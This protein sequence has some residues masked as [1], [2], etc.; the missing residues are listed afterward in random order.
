MNK[1]KFEFKSN[2]I[3]LENLKDF[4]VSNEEFSLHINN[5]FQILKT[6]PFPNLKN[7]QF[8][9]SSEEYISHTD[10]NKSFTDK[11]YQT[12]KK[13]AI[14]KKMK[15][16]KKY[17]NSE[18]I[19]LL[20]VGCGTGDF[21]KSCSKKNKWNVSGVEPNDKARIKAEEKNLVIASNYE[22]LICK[23]FHCITLWHVLEHLPNID[24]EFNKFYQLLNNQGILILALPNY[25]S[26]DAKIYKKN[27]AAFDVPRHLWHFSKTS[28]FKLA[29]IYNFEVL[30]VLPMYFDSFY[31][32]MLSEKNA[33]NKIKLTK[34][35]LNGFYSNISGFFT[36]EYSSQIYILKKRNK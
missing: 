28:I 21:L 14:D 15:L 7:L 3:Y 10:S 19:N 5:E 1:K 23:N 9:Y 25:N 32:S 8:Y 35:F 13:Y 36:K 29:S 31:V 34:A 33:I 24:E 12:I 11:I 6:E 20:D 30:D 4:S 16:V 17:Q 2:G 22:H 26:K 27:W 18:T